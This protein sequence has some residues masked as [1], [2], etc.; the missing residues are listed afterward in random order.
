MKRMQLSRRLL[1][2]LLATGLTVVGISITP[3]SATSGAD[4]V[5]ADIQLGKT[6]TASSSL[7]AYPV[8]NA[9]DSNQAS[10]WESNNNAFP[11][12]IQADLGSAKSVSRVVL[13][14][15]TTW[16]ART[17]TLS[18]RTSTNGTTFTDLVASAGRTFTPSGNTVTISFTATTTRY[19]RLNITANTQWPA[20]QLSEFE[21][22]GPDGGSGGDTQAPTAP[23]TLSF[24]QPASGQI[25]LAWGA[26]TDNVGVTGYVVYRNNAPVTTVTGTVFTDVQPTSATV[27]YFVRARDAAGNESADSNHVTRAGQGGVGSDLAAGKPIEASSTVHTFV[28]TN[29]NDG[30][31]ASYWESAAGYPSTLTVKLGANADVTSVVV[32]LNPDQAWG[33]RTQNIQVLGRDQ[34]ATGFTSLQARADYAFN[35]ATN[36]NSVTIPVTGRA[37]DVRLQFFS[38][39]GAPGGQVAEFQVIGT[40][41]PNPDLTVSS[42][43]WSPAS[44]TEVTPI[45]LT[46]TV[47]NI[48]TAA[49]GATTVNV[50]L[51]GA[52]V[53]SAPVGALAAGASSTVSVN[54]GTRPAGSYTVS[55]T[56]DPT[57]TVVEQNDAN[58]RF[59]AAD[60]ARGR[61]G[62]GPGPAGTRRHGQPVEPGG[63]LVGH[64][65]RVGAQPRHQ[66]GGRVGHPAHGGRPPR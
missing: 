41:A 10:Y 2:G 47:R 13:K 33:A 18:V 66:R 30:N 48:G 8:G 31:V 50:S 61:P 59:T 65:H 25:R 55:S 21:L 39:T 49:A 15:P 24:T 52:V 7:P 11:Q 54:A 12:W 62:A 35:P 29:A 57:N 1:A 20:A 56:V 4:A 43:T 6:L 60:A 9:G 37:A 38:N 5:A 16:E 36:Q 53:G 51:G 28:A 63:R 17:Q 40:A 19:V 26:A 58:N 3:A 45:T 14:L 46:A 27:E 32:K 64:V 22:W 34:A 23:G 44:P 42:T